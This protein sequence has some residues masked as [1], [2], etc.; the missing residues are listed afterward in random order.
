MESEFPPKK[1]GSGTCQFHCNSL[2][3]PVILKILLGAGG[4]VRPLQ[5]DCASCLRHK[6]RKFYT[7]SS[8]VFSWLVGRTETAAR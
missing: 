8:E 1:S 4:A 3:L 2:L 7:P 5:K 6:L